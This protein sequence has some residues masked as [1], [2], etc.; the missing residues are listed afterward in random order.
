MIG[1]LLFSAR[2]SLPCLMSWLI[3]GIFYLL[4]R[5]EFILKLPLRNLRKQK[6]NLRKIFP[7]FVFL[8]Y[9]K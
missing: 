8:T 3:V 9:Y 7:L 6:V 5:I 4:V 1:V 2:C